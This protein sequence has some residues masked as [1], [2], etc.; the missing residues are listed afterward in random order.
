ME[1]SQEY[2]QTQHNHPQGTPVQNGAAQV[3]TGQGMTGQGMTGQGM[4]EQGM[5]GQGIST[6]PSAPAQGMSMSE[7]GQHVLI[8]GWLY[9]VGY[10]LF[11]LVGVFVFIL[12]S[13]IGVASRDATAV[14]VLSTVG[15]FVAAILTL[16]ALP[17]MIAGVGLLR[18]RNWGRILAVV[19]GILG[20]S[21]VPI[22]TLMGIYAL[23][24]L[25]KPEA[26]E[27]FAS[28]Q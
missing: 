17:G 6:G 19:V 3:V 23:I 27:Y 4:T 14:M 8:L 21:N 18:R 11:L 10:S 9:I 12:L 15:T 13:G 22:G 24:M 2:T 7:F 5:T 20:L 1:N 16:L 25:T 28:P 26:T